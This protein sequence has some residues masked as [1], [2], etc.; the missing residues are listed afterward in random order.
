[1]TSTAA[2]V[3]S[4]HHHGKRGESAKTFGVYIR[5]QLTSKI[6]LKITEISKDVKKNLEKKIVAG[7]E[8]RCISEG[9]VKSNSVN[10]ITYSSGNVRGDIIEFTVVFECKISHPVEGMLIDATAKTIT[11]AGIHAEVEDEDGN[12][13]ITIF[14]A[15]DHHHID[16]HFNSIKENA[17]IN[18]KV[19]GVR[20]ELN[21]PY[22]SVIAK[23]MEPAR[24]R[25]P[26]HRGG[27]QPENVRM[28][29]SE[30][31]MEDYDD[32]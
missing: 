14:V 2:V 30:V 28:V 5:S 8:G 31:N 10:I 27:Q 13:P 24:Q 17:R 23:L 12:I 3:S 20:Y 18:I 4:H 19:I 1:M 29:I 6:S 22:I 7:M 15:R 21:D 25:Q 26:H 16:P 11:K 9:Y 32:E